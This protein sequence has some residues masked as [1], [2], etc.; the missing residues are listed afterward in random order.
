[1]AG[2]V[3]GKTGRTEEAEKGA[4][5]GKVVASEAEG[6]AGDAEGG[7]RD[8]VWWAEEAGIDK[9]QRLKD[10][11]KSGEAGWRTGQFTV[12]RKIRND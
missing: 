10:G 3:E 7:A 4:G 2:E 6:E 5:E 1:L 8:A 11:R 9:K 12:L